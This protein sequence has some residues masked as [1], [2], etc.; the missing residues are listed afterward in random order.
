[1]K[2]SYG[3]TYVAEEFNYDPHQ[4]KIRIVFQWLHLRI[5]NFLTNYELSH[6]LR[7]ITKT[8]AEQINTFAATMDAQTTRKAMEIARQKILLL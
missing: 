2:S 7:V 3:H 1:M 5:I 4:K 6:T 8:Y